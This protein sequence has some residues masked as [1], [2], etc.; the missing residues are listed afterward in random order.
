MKREGCERLWSTWGCPRPQRGWPQRGDHHGPRGVEARA[1]MAKRPRPPCRALHGRVVW[2]GVCPRGEGGAAWSLH[3]LGAQPGRYPSAALLGPSAPAHTLNTPPIFLIRQ[4]GPPYVLC[5]SSDWERS[6]LAS[7]PPSSNCA[8][9]R[10]YDIW[11]IL[12]ARRRLPNS[13]LS[14]VQV[15]PHLKIPHQ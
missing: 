10:P 5:S 15:P 11:P 9:F 13:T 12:I 6:G 8:L 7:G 1:A 3:R 4:Q 14:Q 2:A